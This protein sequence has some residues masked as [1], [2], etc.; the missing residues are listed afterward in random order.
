MEEVLEG[1]DTVVVAM[2]G[3]AE[4]EAASGEEGG[5]EEVVAEEEGRQAAERRSRPQ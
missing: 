3:S 2:Q 5:E 4:G 1:A